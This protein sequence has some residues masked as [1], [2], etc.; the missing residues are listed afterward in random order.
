MVHFLVE[1]RFKSGSHLY[2][3]VNMLHFRVELRSI[4]VVINVQM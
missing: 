3:D 4:A 1:L 2:S